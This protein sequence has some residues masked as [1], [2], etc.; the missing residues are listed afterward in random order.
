MRQPIYIMRVEGAVN[1]MHGETI[2]LKLKIH[3][4]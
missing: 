3:E 1:K 2:K 4:N